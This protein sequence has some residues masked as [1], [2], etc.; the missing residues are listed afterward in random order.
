MN[1]LKIRIRKPEDEQHKGMQWRIDYILLHTT[2]L[3]VL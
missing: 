3:S 1:K 2:Q